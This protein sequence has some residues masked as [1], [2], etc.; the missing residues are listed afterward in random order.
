MGLRE[1]L[2]SQ[3][4]W[5][6]RWRSYVPLGFVPV[7]AAAIV[8]RV[9]H[10]HHHDAAQ[11]FSATNELI[12]EVACFG[13]SL[14]GLITR[15]LTIGWAAPRTSGRNTRQQ[16]A[17]DLNTTGMYSIVRHP[18]Y[19]GNYLVGLGVSMA[20]LAW[21]LPI[22]YSLVFWLYY[23]RIMFAEEEFL[24]TTFGERFVNWSSSVPAFTPLIWR[25]TRVARPYSISAVLRGEHPTL[26]MIVVLFAGFDAAE[27]WCVENRLRMDLTWQILLGVSALMYVLFRGAKKRGAWRI[28]MGAW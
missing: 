18:L 1:E 7:V 13:I 28:P 26:F 6:F 22:F 4:T 8:Y 17:D 11:G 14:S 25:W 10:G 21:W 27:N 9:Q 3:G 5:L 15:V 12:W 23:E 20:P 19:L 2:A 16:R 24:R